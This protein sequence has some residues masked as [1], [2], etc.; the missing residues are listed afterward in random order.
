MAVIKIDPDKLTKEFEKRNLIKGDVSEAMGHNRNYMSDTIRRK[1]ISKHA[2]VFLHKNYNI[3][4]K[5]Y[6]VIQEGKR[7]ENPKPEEVFLKDMTDKQAYR[8]IYSAVYHAVKKA[9]SE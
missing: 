5:D 4:L 7:E 1:T 3:D 6:E 9:W 8:L 2:V